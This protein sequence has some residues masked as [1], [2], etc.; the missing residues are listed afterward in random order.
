MLET[1]RTVDGFRSG[2]G[3]K[4]IDLKYSAKEVLETRRERKHVL[5]KRVRKV[6]RRLD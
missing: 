1:S 3:G 2:K 5:I 4:C 6:L